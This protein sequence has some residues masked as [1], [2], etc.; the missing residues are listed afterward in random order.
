MLSYCGFDLR[1]LMIKDVEHL[2]INLLAICTSFLKKCIQVFCL[3]FNQVACLLF[4]LLLSYMGSSNILDINLIRYTA[5]KYFLPTHRLPFHVLI[6]SFA[7]QK[8]FSLI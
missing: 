3:F 1:F 5:W 7:M 4:L 6:I 8:L 2:F